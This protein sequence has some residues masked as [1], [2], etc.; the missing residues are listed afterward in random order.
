MPQV[1][2]VDDDEPNLQLYSA[3]IKRVIGA[4]ASAFGNPLEALIAIA[5]AHPAL[6]VVDYNMPEIDGIEFTR[7]M[8][9]IPGRE[10][11][12]VIMI[13]GESDALLEERA[14]A[15]GVTVFLTKPFATVEFVHHVR[16]L[17]GWGER[18]SRG[19]VESIA[20]REREIILRLHRAMETRDPRIAAH[21][22][23]ARDVAV[24]LAGELGLTKREIEHLRWAGLVYD[25]GK[26]SIPETILEAPVRLSPPSRAVVNNHA[27]AGAVILAGSESSLLQTAESI[28]R[29][30]HERYDGS[31]YP[32]GLQG[33]QIPLLARVMAVAD[34]FAALTSGRPHRA[35]HSFDSALEELQRLRGSQFDPRIIAAFERI[36]DRL[37]SLPLSA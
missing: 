14:L 27:E 16:N 26:L 31:G 17:S 9:S 28:A 37:A 11:T 23:H 33:E 15:S 12:P 8:R 5:E 34:A 20:E 13:T 24:E 32:T 4:E 7:R 10:K 2:V 18:S 22:R 29:H 6:V 3:V 30:H 35:K 1:I 19:V 21:M 36:K 25:I